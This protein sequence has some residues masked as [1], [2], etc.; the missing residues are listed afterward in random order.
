MDHHR[1][2]EEVGYTLGAKIG[3]GSYAT[4]M[5]AKYKD[6]RG[7]VLPLACKIVDKRKAPKEF[8][9]R[10][11][12]R[13]ISILTKIDHACIIKTHSIL[14]RGLHIFIFMRIAEKGDLLNYIKQNGN[15]QESLAK[16]WFYQM[17]KGIQYL[18][19]INVA[20]RDL[21]CE[22]ILITK[23]MNIKIADFGFAG[24]CCNS[25]GETLYSQTYCGS[26]GK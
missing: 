25:A 7:R 26:A 14:K 10:F 22:N 20:H 24:Y 15:L 16:E 18:H 1:A 6:S 17:L 9:A 2:L 19:S 3:K 5:D 23:H 13:E 4:V 21:K 11:F 8:L 12:H